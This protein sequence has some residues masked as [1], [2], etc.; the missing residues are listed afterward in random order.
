MAA[1]VGFLVV[2]AGSIAI[3]LAVAGPRPA[4]R[5][6]PTFDIDAVAGRQVGV[7]SS[8]AGFAVTGLVFLVTQA[9]NVPTDP[10]GPFTTALVMFV[11]AYMGYF[12]SSLL[13]ASVSHRADDAPFDLAAAQHAGAS[14]TLFSAFIG[15]LAL[16]PLFLAFELRAIADLAAWF[17]VGAIAVGYGFLATALY[18]TGFL[19]A[20]LTLLLPVLA[21]AGV[22]GYGWLVN[23]AAPDLRSSDA[24]VRLTVTSFVLGVPAYLALTVL[25]ILAHR[26]RFQPTLAARWHL[27]IVAYAEAVTVLIGFLFLAVMGLA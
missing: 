15:W 10:T 4:G 25:P 8:L 23:A 7:L 6:D 3:A 13:F 16:R 12:S 2:A 21:I 20:R 5:R 9:H 24:A 11:V 27:V 26:E 18:R 22:I 14:I 1:V 17:L 19:T